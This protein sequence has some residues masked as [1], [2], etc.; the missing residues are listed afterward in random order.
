MPL[1]LVVL[2]GEA[3]DPPLVLDQVTTLPEVETALLFASESCAV[4]VTLLPATGE[5]LLLVTRY[6]VAVPAT[7]VAV[8]V[9][10][11]PVSPVAVAVSVFD[12]AVVPSVQLV[13]EA[14]PLELVVTADV[15]TTVPPP[16]AT[17]NVTLTP[18]TGLLFASLTI[19]LGAMLTALPAVAD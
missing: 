17:A 7:A 14:M 5:E 3:N 1:A 11:L 16:D 19:T 15:G 2:V 12:P 9:T 8:N 4:M 6:L 10:G 18:E 13:V